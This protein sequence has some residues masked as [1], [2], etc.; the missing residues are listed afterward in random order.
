[1]WWSDGMGKIELD[2][3]IDL[4]KTCSHPGDCESDVRILM[5]NQDIKAQ[6]DKIDPV[7]LRNTLSEYGAWD[8]AEL[9]DHGMNLA[10]VLWIACNDLVEEYEKEQFT[11][12]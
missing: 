12:Q 10:R 8:D 6:L 11:E 4:A 2:V 1:M 5:Q 3:D 7:E 9:Q